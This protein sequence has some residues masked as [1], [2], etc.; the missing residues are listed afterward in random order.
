MEKI[1]Q[2]Y[3]KTQIADICEVPQKTVYNW[4]KCKNMPYWALERLGFRVPDKPD[5]VELTK[6]HC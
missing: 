2:Y 3:S 5:I 4:F 1:L 6:P